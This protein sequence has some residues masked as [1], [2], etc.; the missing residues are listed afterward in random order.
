MR[1]NNSPMK[2]IRGF[3]IINHAAQLVFVFVIK[4][5]FA[6]ALARDWPNNTIWNNFHSK[7]KSA[8]L[9]STFKGIFCNIQSFL[10]TF[11]AKIPFVGLVPRLDVSLI[12]IDA[13]SYSPPHTTFS[14]KFAPKLMFSGTI[15][16]STFWIQIAHLLTPDTI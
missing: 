5:R 4:L 14:V 11:I 7:M 1:Y 9:Q 3:F 12:I 6:T 8:L 10:F 2:A 13:C 16:S 15:N